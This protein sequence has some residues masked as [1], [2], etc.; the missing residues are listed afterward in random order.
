M[1]LNYTE[2]ITLPSDRYQLYAATKYGR[3][4]VLEAAQSVGVNLTRPNEIVDQIG[5]DEHRGMSLKQPVIAVPMTRL[6]MDC[7]MPQFMSEKMGWVNAN[8]ADVVG[9]SVSGAY[10]MYVKVV[11]PIAGSGIYEYRALAQDKISLAESG[12]AVKVSS[13]NVGSV[14]VMDGSIEVCLVDLSGKLRAGDTGTF[15]VASI[16]H[17]DAESDFKQSSTDLRLVIRDGLG[18]IHKTWYLPD[19]AAMSDRVTLTADGKASE[20]I[21]FETEI[22]QQY[23][24]Y[25]VK[26]QVVADDAKMVAAA[27]SLDTIY[28]SESGI[29]VPQAHKVGSPYAGNHFIKLTRWQSNGTKAVLTEKSGI[30]PTSLAVDEV[31]YDRITNKLGFK[32][33]T[34]VSGDRVEMT[35]YTLKSGSATESFSE[36]FDNDPISI[37][38]DYSP[39]SIGVNQFDRATSLNISVAFKRERKPYLGETDVKYSLGKVPDITGDVAS[40]DEDL[41]L[42]RLLSKG[43]ATD[44]DG[45]YYA[46]ELGNYTNENNIQLVANLKD[47]SDNVTQVIKYTIPSIVVTE[48]TH[49]ISVGND[50]TRNFNWVNKLGSLDI[51]RK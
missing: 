46:K 38:G 24:G 13:L 8:P 11:A 33:G 44:A 19:L 47:P 10:K 43:S 5:D 41:E 1:N 29:V 23:D 4:K 17:W 27:L 49:D 18:S 39:V 37:P 7:S 12:C 51:D 26:R 36:T 21:D 34:L 50:T 16:D 42:V 2:S 40:N 3:F 14:G 6:I 25:V 48:M 35:F 32:P 20:S 30:T 15:K 31:Q 28:A 22:F 9:T 45:E